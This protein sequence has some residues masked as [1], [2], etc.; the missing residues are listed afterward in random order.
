MPIDQSRPNA[1]R[2]AP[3]PSRSR[4]PTA[5]ELECYQNGRDRFPDLAR[6]G[7]F[8]TW[9]P[10]E[11]YSA[12]HVDATRFNCISW[13]VGHTDRWIEPGTVEEM[14]RLYAEYHFE[15]CAD[16]VAEVELY[17][18]LDAPLRLRS[19]RGVEYENS[20]ARVLHA[21]RRSFPE[22]DS[23][24]EHGCSSKLSDGPLIAH[25]RWALEDRRP[26]GSRNPRIP[27]GSIYQHWRRAHHHPSFPGMEHNV[28]NATGNYPDN[29]MFMYG[30]GKYPPGHPGNTLGLPHSYPGTQSPSSSSSKRPMALPGARSKYA[31]VPRMKAHDPIP[32]PSQA[33]QASAVNRYKRL[34]GSS[35]KLVSKFKGYFHAWQKTWFESTEGLSSAAEARCNTTEFYTLVQM[36]REILPLVNYML[37]SSDSFTAVFLYNALEDDTRYRVDP[38]DVLNFLV[39]Q[40]QQNLIIDVN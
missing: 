8:G 29:P 11:M 2:P 9:D 39:L 5:G 14:N 25:N 3:D 33:A 30:Y 27:Y 6:L 26:Y 17:R 13:S 21:H 40:R 34:E 22:L 38:H 18:I 31:Q 4:K 15:E 19:R 36:G 20:N 24:P 7:S 1:P 37:L 10:E 35:P 32:S 28:V 12:A 23:P 16:D